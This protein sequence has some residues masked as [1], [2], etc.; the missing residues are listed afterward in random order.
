MPPPRWLDWH[1]EVGRASAGVEFEL[2]ENSHHM[3]F[4]DEEALFAETVIRFLSTRP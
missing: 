2:F 1:H 4:I 3:P